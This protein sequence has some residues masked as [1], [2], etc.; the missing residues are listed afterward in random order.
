MHSPARQEGIPAFTGNS[1][2]LISVLWLAMDARLGSKN[3]KPHRLIT[4]RQCSAMVNQPRL[5][6]FSES[7]WVHIDRDVNFE[8]ETIL[9]YFALITDLLESPR[10]PSESSASPRTVTAH[11]SATQFPI[12]PLTLKR[13]RGST[14]YDFV[15]FLLYNSFQTHWIYWIAWHKHPKRVC[16]GVFWA[17]SKNWHWGASE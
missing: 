7:T 16:K 2:S 13:N 11:Q 15:H 1:Y 4:S 14:M 3:P 6:D 12:H 8:T 5:T 17:I 10:F 9:D